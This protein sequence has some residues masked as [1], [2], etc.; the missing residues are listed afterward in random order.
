MAKGYGRL[1]WRFLLQSLTAFGFSEIARDLIYRLMY[2]FYINAET[3]GKV[4][5]T[6]GVRQ[7][8]PLSLLVI[9]ELKWVKQ[10]LYLV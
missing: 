9:F 10:N 7:G 1:E 8:D 5:S 4:Q 3:V 2:S 6:R